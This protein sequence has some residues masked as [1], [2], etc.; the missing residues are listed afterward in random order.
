MSLERITVVGSGLM[1]YGIAMIFAAQGHVVKLVDNDESKLSSAKTRVLENLKTMLEHGIKFTDAPEIILERIEIST[2]LEAAC[3]NSD[4]VIEAVFEDMALKQ[5]V[6]ADLDRYCTETTIL[7]SNTSVMSI[8]EI[9]SKSIHRH[10]IVGTHFW[11]PPHLIPLVEVVKAQDSSD[12]AVNA[13]YA[14]LERVGKRP[15]KVLKDVPGF[16]ANR[17]QHALWREAFHMIDEGICDAHTV[18]Q[19]IKNG[20]GLRWSVLGPVE[21]ADLVGLDLSKA[22]HDYLLPHLN[23]SPAPSRTLLEHVAKNKLGFKTHQGFFSWTDLE[24]QALRERLAHHLLRSQAE[25]FKGEV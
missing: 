7:C 9:A 13:T 21:N 25:T 14:L 1:G 24:I 4:F 8:T 12:E 15:I 3:Q 6:F 20:P 18:D 10:R 17:L 2:D 16:V 5:Q 22:I 11:N 19:A 23:A